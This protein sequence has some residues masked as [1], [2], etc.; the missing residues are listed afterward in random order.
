MT[1]EFRT[2]SD[3]MGELQVP[4]D[5]L[6]GAQTQRAVDNFPISGITMPR[7]FIRALGLIKEAAA[8]VNHELGLLD[9]AKAEAIIAVS[10]KVADGE[11]DDH[12]PID[13]FQTGSGTSS[14][15]N[16]NEVIAHLANQEQDLD[17]HP[18]DDVNMCQSSNDVIPTAI[19][20]SGPG[21]S[22]AGTG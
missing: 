13:V 8:T 14:N 12:F 7:Q 4:A 21:P 18:N 16:A 1:D 11:F 15:M 2:E 6:W 20:L 10:E 3:S 19:Q 5:A 22:S 9:A 17:I